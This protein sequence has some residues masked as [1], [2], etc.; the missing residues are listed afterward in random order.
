MSTPLSWMLPLRRDSRSTLMMPAWPM[1][2]LTVTREGRPK[3]EPPRSRT[4]SPF[5]WPT[6]LPSMSMRIVPLVISSRISSSTRLARYTRPASALSTWRG[7]PALPPPPPPPPPPPLPRPELE[8]ALDAATVKVRESL[9]LAE[10][11]DPLGVH[12]HVVG[13]QLHRMAKVRRS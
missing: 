10:L 11:G 6:F 1:A 9:P 8:Q 5:T 2:T 13:F 7:G 3:A 4:D 12:H